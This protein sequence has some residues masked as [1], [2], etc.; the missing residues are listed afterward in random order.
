MAAVIVIWQ[1]LSSTGRLPETIVGSPAAVWDQA[2]T[3]IGNGQLGAAIGASVQRVALGLLIGG[4]A[5]IALALISGLSRVGEDIVDA[6]VQMVRTVPFVGII[7][8][9]IIWLGVGQTPKVALI[10]LG[11]MFPIYL[12]LTAGIRAVDPALVEAGRA[13]GLGR[14]GVI[15]HVILPSALPQLLVGVRFA[16]GISWLALIFAEQISA[17]N[18]LGELMSTAQE[19]LQSN[20]IMVCLVVYALLGLAADFIVR[21]LERLLLTWRPRTVGGA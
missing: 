17:T 2:M 12:N 9:L 14:I 6:P 1:L 19:L 10:A 15:W 7:P 11:V 16:L 21:G 4:A 20:T 18:G 3:L 5:G 13:M 8:L